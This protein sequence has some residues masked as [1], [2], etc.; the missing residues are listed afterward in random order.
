MQQNPESVYS[1]EQNTN[2]SIP[3]RSRAKREQTG[4]G[5]G[6][7]RVELSGDDYTSH[8]QLLQVLGFYRPRFQVQ[9]LHAKHQNQKRTLKPL[10]NALY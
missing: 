3:R 1:P 5:F 8:S 7:W 2:I 4:G 10:H 9:Q 6:E